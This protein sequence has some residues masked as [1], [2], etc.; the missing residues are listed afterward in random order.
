MSEEIKNEKAEV[1]QEDL[2]KLK[3]VVSRKHIIR[4]NSRR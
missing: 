4:K 3:A 2:K 1:S